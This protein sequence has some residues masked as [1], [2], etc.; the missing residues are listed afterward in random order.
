MGYILCHT[1]SGAIGALLS[2]VI[3]SEKLTWNFAVALAVM[4]VG[5][6]FAAVD[7]KRN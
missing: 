2:F 4:L 5:T 3:L 6:Y 7:G 1:R